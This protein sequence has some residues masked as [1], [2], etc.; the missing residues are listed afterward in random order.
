MCGLVGIYSSN[1]FQKHKECLAYLL[2]VDTWR[3]RDSTGVAAIRGNADT[4]TLKSTV[5]G[6]EFVDNK[7]FDDHLKYNDIA[8]IGHNRYGTIGR[9]I[10]S[11]AHPFEVLDDGGACLLVGAHNGTLKNKGALADH[12]LFGTDSEALFNN[13][14]LEGI[15]KTIEKVEGAWALTWYDHI[16]E[17]LRFLRNSERTL[18]YAYEEGKKTLIWASEAWMI[19][20]CCERANIK[21]EEGKVFTVLEDTL[22]RFPVPMKINEELKC[23]RKG[24]VV[25]KQA[26]VGFFRR[27][28]QGRGFWRNGVWVEIG[29]GNTARGPQSQAAPKVAQPSTATSQAALMGSVSIPNNSSSQSGTNVKSSGATLPQKNESS[30]NEQA[31]ADNV[32]PIDKAKAFKGYEGKRI[33]KKVLEAA[34]ANGCG[35]CREEHIAMGDKYGWLEKG[36]AVCK[37]CLEGEEKPSVDVSGK[38]TVH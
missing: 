34:L 1:L 23:E 20:V 9:N 28:E 13:I 36:V 22:Y 3:G 26:P 2:Y 16:E 12:N 31:P 33:T 17:E 35:W 14:A 29:G 19:R 10:K 7:K 38:V 11:N 27:E 8:W 4:Q 15:E 18:F 6:Y 5:P 37:K 30:S 21:L 25:G 24:G 32:T